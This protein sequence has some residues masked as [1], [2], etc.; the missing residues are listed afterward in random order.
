MEENLQD[1]VDIKA[2]EFRLMRMLHRLRGWRMVDFPFAKQNLSFAQFDL[3][4]Y[5]GQHPGSHIQEVAAGMGLTPP[6]VSVGIKRLEEDGWL[7]RRTDP[8][9]GRA[10]RIYPTQKSEET[11][12]KF[13]SAQI[14]ATRIFL[15]ALEPDE[16]EQLLTL[17]DKAMNVVEAT[18]QAGQDGKNQTK[19]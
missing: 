11:R 14:E 5:L 8:A 4:H 19:L 10:F 7:E 12:Q 2:P 6:T 18:Q 1:L 13:L 15:A 17:L 9:D 16:Q 3:L